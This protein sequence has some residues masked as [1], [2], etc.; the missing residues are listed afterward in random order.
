MAPDGSTGRG[1]LGFWVSIEPGVVMAE[2]RGHPAAAWVIRAVAV[3]VAVGPLVALAMA[4]PY[5]E[6]VGGLNLAPLWVIVVPVVLLLLVVGLRL[7]RRI[8]AGARAE[9]AVLPPPSPDEPPPPPA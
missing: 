6:D 5:I 1:G 9:G 7:A 2:R 4:T 3:L 8:A